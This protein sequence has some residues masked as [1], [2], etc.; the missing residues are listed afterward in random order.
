MTFA[1]PRVMGGMVY[2]CIGGF[3]EY[4]CAFNSDDGSPRWWTP[5]DARVVSMPFME[6]A[7]PLVTDGIVYSGTYALN[8]QDG[9]VL[10]RI[11]IDTDTEGALSLHALTGETLYATSHRGIYAINAQDGQIRWLYQPE[12][13]LSGPPVVSGQVVYAGT[14][15]SVGYPPKSYCRALD[16]ETGA[17]IWRYPMGGYTGA[18]VQHETIYVS[19]GDGSLYALEKSR[20]TLRWQRSFD[21]PGHYPAIIAEN[22]LYITADGAY[23]L[24]SEDGAVLWHQ[25]LESGLSVS[26]GQP[27]VQSGAVY[28]ARTDRH[29][30]GTLYALNTR[31]GAE[32]WHTSYLS[33]P[34]VA[35]DAFSGL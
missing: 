10:W 20:G 2:V 33:L 3:G 25:D 31:T 11:L 30:R 8:K 21:A 12:A 22:V 14:F 27:V 6:W 4:T 19:S 17:V 18:V 34:A 29:G 5:T 1:T 13:S 16:A 32:Y 35:G 15:G 7:V 28:L 24:S 9:S 26:F 23:A